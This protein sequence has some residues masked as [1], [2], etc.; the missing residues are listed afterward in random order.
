MTCK[1]DQEYDAG[2]CYTKCRA[3][4]KGIG[5]VC[6]GSCSGN[7]NSSRTACGAFCTSNDQACVTKNKILIEGG[8]NLGLSGLAAYAAPTPQTITKLVQSNIGLAV[9]LLFDSKFSNQH[10]TQLIYLCYLNF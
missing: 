5:P 8:I 2:L 10:L 4:Y 3:G 9:E 6:W 1:S 7:S